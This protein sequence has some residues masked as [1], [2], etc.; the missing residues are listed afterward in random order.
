[1]E[2]LTLLTELF[3]LLSVRAWLAN[4]VA[5]PLT[6]ADTDP[7]TGRPVQCDRCPPGT[8]LRAG[9]SSIRKSDCAACP[10]GSFTEL[11]NYIG[12][13]LRCGVCGRNQVV[14]KE[15]TAD[16][17]CQCECKQGYF[18]HQ[19]YDMC[20]RHSECPSGHGVLTR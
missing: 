1:M 18:Y 11:W 6:Y 12:R 8:Y 13:C 19:A 16:S 10:D 2:F 17:D 5:A 14:K 4:S 3:I 20:L 7:I 15:C 9:C